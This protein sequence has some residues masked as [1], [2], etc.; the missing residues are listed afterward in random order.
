[1]DYEEEGFK[2]VWESEHYLINGH[3]YYCYC[4]F[5]EPKVLHCC[6]MDK[7]TDKMDNSLSASMYSVS[8]DFYFDKYVSDD[9][10]RTSHENNEDIGEYGKLIITKGKI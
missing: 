7:I 5:T 3:R 10:I 8:A 2:R 4:A 6:K 9:R 1:M